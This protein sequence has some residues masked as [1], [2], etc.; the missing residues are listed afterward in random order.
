[1]RARFVPVVRVIRTIR[2]TLSPSL[3]CL[4]H[5]AFTFEIENASQ[6]VV[7]RIS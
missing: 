1:M 7:N 6:I 3:N 5:K 2:I 4:T